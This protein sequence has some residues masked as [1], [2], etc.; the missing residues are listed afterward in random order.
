M[1]NKYS[2]LL[3]A[4]LAAVSV[5][6]CSNAKETLGLTRSAPDE[7]AVVKRAP[8]EMPPD[9]GLR[10]P[11]PGAP[12]PQEQAMEEQAREAVFGGDQGARKAAP[13][14]GEA[15]LLQEAGAYETDPNIRGVV[16]KEANVVDNS[17]KP[18]VQRLL[19]LKRPGS[20][21]DEGVLNPKKEAARLKGEPLPE[22]EE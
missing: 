10:P 8:L 12:R 11:K 14:N 7:F 9:Y 16:D 4:L 22:E 15:A 13:A 17:K 5:S 19:G 21:E 1:N 3:V 18:V 6:A 2:L 20:E